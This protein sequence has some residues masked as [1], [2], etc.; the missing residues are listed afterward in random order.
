M[1]NDRNFY[2]RWRVYDH[3]KRVIWNTIDYFLRNFFTYGTRVYVNDTSGTLVRFSYTNANSFDRVCSKTV[4]PPLPTLMGVFQIVSLA[5]VLKGTI[6]TQR[7]GGYPR[8]PFTVELYNFALRTLHE[9]TEWLT[10]SRTF[11][12]MWIYLGYVRFRVSF[13]SF[14]SYRNLVRLRLA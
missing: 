6:R 12:F 14:D 1:Y 4:L 7:R 9:S 10:Q 8:H 3:T 11:A 2:A 13:D 5:I